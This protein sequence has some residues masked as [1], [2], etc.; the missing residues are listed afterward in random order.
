M[1]NRDAN[2]LIH[3]CTTGARSD[4]DLSPRLCDSRLA[5]GTL[6]DGIFIRSHLLKT[7]A[8]GK[9]PILEGLAV[10]LHVFGF[11]AFI[12]ILWVM[13]SR[14]DTNA[15]FTHFQDE[16]DWGSIGLATLIGVVGP[17]TTYLGG[18][19]AVHLSE[20][21]KDASY[22]LPRAMVS[23][24]LINYGL[25]FITTVTFMF[26]LGNINADLKDPSN[27][28]WTAVIYRITGS[29]AATIVLIIIMMMMVSSRDGDA[30]RRRMLI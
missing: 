28:P 27:Q 4:L 30:M 8:I 10:V 17:A 23:A 24:A 25:G 15:T 14:A 19:S 3:R 16:N 1:A 12:V 6:D 9:L 21:L 22:V 20:E 26:N 2:G 13:G 7:S 11:L 18:D 29:K 5:C